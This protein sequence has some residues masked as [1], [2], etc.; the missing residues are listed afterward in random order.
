MKKIA[1]VALAVVFCLASAGL[2]VAADKP[3][4]AAAPAA[5]KALPMTP[6]PMPRAN[7]SML[8]GT[9][10]KI[11]N[12]DPAN[13]K[14]EVKNEADGAMHTV[15]LTSTTNVTKATDPSELKAGDNVRVMARKVD[16]KEVAMGVM[17][18]N[19]RKPAPRPAAA[20]KMPAPAAPK[21]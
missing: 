20:A 15:E 12:A 19:I 4:K 3:A 11:D 2:A 18:G 6:K 14:L 21:K 7:F 5:G 9:I 8:Y 10:T 17:F 13:I 1:L 16:N